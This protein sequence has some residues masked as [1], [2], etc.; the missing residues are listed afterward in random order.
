MLELYNL[1][2]YE[3]KAASSDCVQTTSLHLAEA[4]GLFYKKNTAGVTQ[5]AIVR[6]VCLPSV[7]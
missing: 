1:L 3:T 7:L 6:N 5:T 4:R 2:I